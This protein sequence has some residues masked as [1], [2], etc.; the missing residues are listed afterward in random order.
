MRQWLLEL[1]PPCLSLLLSCRVTHGSTCAI[2]RGVLPP[3]PHDLVVAFGRRHQVDQLF[4]VGARALAK[5]HHRDETASW[6]GSDVTKGTQPQKNV[7]GLAVLHRVLAD[8]AWANC[9][10]LPHDVVT[11]EVRNS[12]GY[13]ARWTVSPLA[14][15]PAATADSSGAADSNSA[16]GAAA[17]G[18]DAATEEAVPS[19]AFLWIDRCCGSVIAAGTTV[20][21][22]ASNTQNKKVVEFR[23]FLEPHD[24]EGHEKGWRH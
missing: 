2:S 7:A 20:R 12:Q 4:S 8:I 23:G 3:P 18:A 16:S 24:D 21:G 6:W 5:H 14:P 19:V 9:H 22:D 10:M 11:Y 13:G 15:A 1:P 17:A